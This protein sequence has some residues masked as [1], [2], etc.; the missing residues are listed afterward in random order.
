MVIILLACTVTALTVHKL[1][2]RPLMQL[3]GLL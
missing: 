2:T 1:I 3:W